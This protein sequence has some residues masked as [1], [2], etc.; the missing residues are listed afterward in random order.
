MHSTL[1][2]DVLPTPHPR[3][4]KVIINRL[5][6]AAGKAE[7]THDNAI[8][9][10]GPLVMALLAI[11]QIEQIALTQTVLTITLVREAQWDEIFQ[12]IKMVLEQTIDDHDPW[13][14][15]P[16]MRTPS[17]ETAE[18]DDPNLKTISAILDRTVRPYI[19][20]HGGHI[21]L[22]SYDEESNTL[23][24]DFSGSCDGCSASGGSTLYAI[25]GVLQYEFDPAITVTVANPYWEQW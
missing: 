6:R 12:D 13:A 8:E 4:R 20:S 5:L 2:I 15:S 16:E 18:L 21:T 19:S 23:V 7:Y 14:P 3:A 1:E 11:E 25:Q 9:Q 22:I 10:D 17:K 24:L